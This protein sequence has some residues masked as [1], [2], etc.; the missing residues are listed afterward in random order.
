M[1]RNNEGEWRTETIKRLQKQLQHC[2]NQYFSEVYELAL[3]FALNPLRAVG[4]NFYQ[5]VI[6]DAKRT[7]RRAKQ[8]A[9]SFISLYTLTKDGEDEIENPLAADY[10]TPEQQVIYWHSVDL[11]RKA[12]SKKH[13]HSVAVFYSMLEGYTV[14][15]AAKKLCISESMVKKLRAE[16]I[17]LGRAILL[18]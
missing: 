7:I 12:C 10:V 8:N 18:N 2:S 3:D 9:P 15:D 6:N 17:Q 5:R 4:P 14:A 11:L 13:K 1:I 16:I